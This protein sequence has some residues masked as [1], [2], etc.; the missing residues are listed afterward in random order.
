MKAHDVRDPSTS[1]C[2]ILGSMGNKNCYIYD[3]RHCN[4]I[5]TQTSVVH[6][7]SNYIYSTWLFLLL[8]ARHTSIHSYTYIWLYVYLFMAM[9]MSVSGVLFNMII[10]L[11]TTVIKLFRSLSVVRWGRTKKVDL[12]VVAS[13]AWIFKSILRIWYL[14]ALVVFGRHRML[15]Q[16]L[17][18]TFFAISCP[19]SSPDSNVLHGFE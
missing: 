17:N 13:D 5:E 4:G 14:C 3:V 12:I 6:F 15:C 11:T 8:Y 16:L 10:K 9:V 19:Y 7:E 1:P 18:C 2:R